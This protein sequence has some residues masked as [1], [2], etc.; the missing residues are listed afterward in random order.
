MVSNH[1]SH[2]RP[3]PPLHQRRAHLG[4]A[5]L[6]FNYYA[7][8]R[9]TSPP[10]QGVPEYGQFIPPIRKSYRVFQKKLCFTFLLI[11]QL[12]LIVEKRVGYPQNWEG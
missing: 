9:L 7:R 11:S 2:S 5:S 8:A 10:L 3:F 1:S 4:G 6:W 12:I